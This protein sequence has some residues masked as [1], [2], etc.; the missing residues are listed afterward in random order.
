M[1]RAL[2]AAGAALLFATLLGAAE[3]AR[4]KRGAYCPLPEP[5]ETSACLTGAQSEFSEFFAGLEANTALSDEAA[6][7]V[8]AN[9]EGGPNG[10]RPYEALSSLAYGYVALARRAAASGQLDPAT[11]ARL[12][13]WNT[14][15]ENAFAESESDPRFRDALRIAAADIHT[16]APSVGLTCVDAEGNAAKC[17]STESVLRGFGAAR[18]QIGVR[19]QLGRL[20]E[21]WFG[22]EEAP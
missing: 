9:V 15:L 6:A 12:E 5:G 4:P 14:L 7:R 10:V 13:R 21:R 3:E 16:H 18:E 8:E 19:G 17:D 2:A 1:R 11:A 20:F 22:P